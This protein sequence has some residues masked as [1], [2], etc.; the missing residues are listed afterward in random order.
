MLHPGTIFAGDYRV[1]RPLSE[2]GMGSVYVVEQLSTGAQ[3]ALK[4]MRREIVMDP[5]MRDRFLLEA[6]VG[7]KIASDHVVQVLAAGIDQATGMPWLVMEFLVGE[8]LDARIKQRGPM[9]P[10]EVAEVARQMSHALAAAHAVGVVHRDL[11]PGN[12][13]LAASR[14]AVA[15][16]SLKVLDFGIAKIVEEAQ[17]SGTMGLGT[18]LWMAPEQTERKGY[19]GAGTD[20]W[21]FG[22]ITFFMLTGKV[23]WLAAS[24]ANTGIQTLLRELLIEPIVPP[25][26]RAQELGVGHLVPPGFDAWFMRCVERDPAKREGRVA[27]VVGELVRLIEP[28]PSASPAAGTGPTGPTWAQPTAAAAPVSNAMQIASQH[29]PGLAHVSPHAASHQAPLTYLPTSPGA[30]MTSAMGQQGMA[31]AAPVVQPYAQPAPPTQG[32]RGVGLL[33]G[34]GAAALLAGGVGFF[35]LTG[36]K[37]KPSKNTDDDED[38]DERPK[39]KRP[40]AASEDAIKADCFEI[41]VYAAKIAK[42][43]LSDDPTSDELDA[44]AREVDA[45]ALEGERMQLRTTEGRETT[46]DIAKSLR[47]LAKGARTSSGAMISGDQ[48]RAMQGLGELALAYEALKKAAAKGDAAC[49]HAPA[50]ADDGAGDDGV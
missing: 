10:R 45:L 23:F 26:R 39:K 28:A 1:V 43:D 14:T 46:A 16:F 36:S 20:I 19:V 15:A 3:R 40:P 30:P 44:L 25:S 35:A 33:V 12:L 21:A 2:G 42:L 27:A 50:P 34:I 29:P 4:L 11:K 7:S 5:A 17:S 31:T 32:R 24:E 38:E 49:G 41:V 47:D 9:P 37:K 13:F 22:L 8:E 18:P 48:S 6:R